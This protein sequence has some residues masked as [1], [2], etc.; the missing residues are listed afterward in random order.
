VPAVAVNVALVAPTVTET[1]AGTI[2]AELLL[3]R[4]IVAAAEVAAENVTV[5]LEVPPDEMVA[6]LHATAE[7]VTGATGAADTTPPLPVADTPVPAADDPIV[8][9]MLT[10]ALVKAEVVVKEAT[11][12]TP[13][14]I[15][16]A[17]VPD[18]IHI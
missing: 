14:E 16:F 17:F 1:V 10:E 4:L 11:A 12:N 8:F 9:V 6:G 3:E 13:L 15:V 7:I 18:A 2:T 5:Q